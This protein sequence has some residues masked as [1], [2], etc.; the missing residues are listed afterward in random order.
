M[1]CVGSV[2][3]QPCGQAWRP[4]SEQ[5]KNKTRSCSAS[6][7]LAHS[8]LAR[9]VRAANRYDAFGAAQR[10]DRE[11][12]RCSAKCSADE[13]Q[14]LRG[15]R[16][17]FCG[18]RLE[19]ECVKKRMHSWTVRGFRIVACSAGTAGKPESKCSAWR[20][21]QRA[22]RKGRCRGSSVYARRSSV[23][24]GRELVNVG[25]GKRV[26]CLKDEEHGADACSAARAAANMGRGGGGVVRSIGRT[27]VREKARE[28]R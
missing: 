8:G 6:R 23:M 14:D 24:S 28:R 7:V 25:R 15:G 20:G 4:E 16:H 19:P 3:R 22:R 5:N 1:T 18:S 11:S 26:R 21:L 10:C 27:D 9:V 17:C 12:Q 2:A 13:K